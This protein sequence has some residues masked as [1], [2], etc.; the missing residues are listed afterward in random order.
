L[1]CAPLVSVSFRNS[2]CGN[3]VSISF[4]MCGC[5]PLVSVSFRILQTCRIALYLPFPSTSRRAVVPF[6]S[7]I[8]AIRFPQHRLAVSFHVGDGQFVVAWF[9]LPP[10]VEGVWPGPAERE[11]W[12]MG[13]WCGALGEV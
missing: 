2:E 1:E 7:Y 8:S 9:R 6:P 12:G 3:L 10:F 4:R 13:R 11:R 5:V